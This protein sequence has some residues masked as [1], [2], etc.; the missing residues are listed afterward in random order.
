MRSSASPAIPTVALFFWYL[1]LSSRCFCRLK[2]FFRPCNCRFDSFGMQVLLLVKCLPR[3]SFIT[4]IKELGV[5]K[6]QCLKPEMKTE[7]KPETKTWNYEDKGDSNNT[8]KNQIGQ[9]L[10]LKWRIYKYEGVRA[11]RFWFLIILIQR[12]SFYTQASFWFSYFKKNIYIC[13]CKIS[14][15]T[16]VN[17]LVYEYLGYR[18]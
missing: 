7:M 14:L 17:M 3:M 10:S 12:E 1:P 6:M 16:Q 4:S 9:F 2:E 5:S 13:Q 15:P 18:R 8:K 11:V